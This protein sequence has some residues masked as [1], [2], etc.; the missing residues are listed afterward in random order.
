VDDERVTPR[1][2]AIAVL[3]LLLFAPPL[4]S[5]FDED[6]RVGGIPLLWAYL[7]AAWAVVIGLVAA[8]VR[9]SD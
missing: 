2:T 5:L 7:F 3:G 6:A 4:L 8:V 9:R 1:L